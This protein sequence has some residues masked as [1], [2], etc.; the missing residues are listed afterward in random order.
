MKKK[1]SI[2]E[3]ARLMGVAPSTISRA[4]NGMPGVSDELR[5][6]I[7]EKAKD[8]NYVS[9]S[10]LSG[11]MEDKRKIIAVI[12]ND[13]RN[14][15]Y[16]EVMYAIQQRLI[17][18]NYQ[19]II[20]NS[21]DKEE[22]MARLL[23]LIEEL[24]CSGIIH[25]TVPSERS[26]TILRECSIPIILINRMLKGFDTDVVTLDNYE[27]GYVV[28]RYLVEQGHTN[29]GYLKGP[30]ES[31]SS[32]LRFEGYQKAMKNYRFRLPKEAIFQGDLS[33]EVGRQCAEKFTSLRE[34]DRPTAMIISNDLAAHGFIAGCILQG[35]RIPD[36]I[37]VVSFDNNRFA[38]ASEVPITTINCFGDEMGRKAA[39]VMLRRLKNPNKKIEKIIMKPI[40]IKRNSVKNL[41]SEF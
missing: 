26:S 3:F 24:R 37:S 25:L 11:F 4:L 17:E 6:K 1:T 27:A 10:R 8:I 18:E 22:N 19:T 34:A 5:K 13:I 28:T 15:Y 39:E 33:M 30:E 16:S 29:I 36:D 2:T 14:P 9:Y 31:S 40:L 7:K 12:A 21:G 41:N 32:F 23:K 38:A 35:L 20:F